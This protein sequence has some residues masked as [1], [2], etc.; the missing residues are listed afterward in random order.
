[1]S[2]DS[3]GPLGHL[4]D[5]A[6]FCTPEEVS[7]FSEPKATEAIE[8][9]IDGIKW[10]PREDLKDL[11]T[12]CDLKT[13]CKLRRV[14]QYWK[15]LVS[16][17]EV[18]E[19]AVIDRTCLN[20]SRGEDHLLSKKEP[21]KPSRLHSH[22]RRHG[23]MGDHVRAIIFVCRGPAEPWDRVRSRETTR[24]TGDLSHLFRLIRLIGLFCS[25][26]RQVVLLRMVQDSW[27]GIG[28]CARTLQERLSHPAHLPSGF[29]HLQV[30]I[31]MDANFCFYVNSPGYRR[32]IW[33]KVPLLQCELTGDPADDVQINLERFIWPYPSAQRDWLARNVPK[34]TAK[35]QAW[36]EENKANAL[37]LWGEVSDG[38]ADW[39][40]FRAGKYE[41]MSAASLRVLAWILQTRPSG[42]VCDS[43]DSDCDGEELIQ[44][45]SEDVDIEAPPFLID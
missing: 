45:V 7:I 13:R 31:L 4:S 20:V 21:R 39:E 6:S 28:K 16:L 8:P 27:G 3:I 32:A 5:Y 25:Q 1:M 44:A 30:L 15:Y 43:D 36:L 12:F 23:L 22:M 37:V 9:I 42:C 18:N 38:Y 11:F 10:V 34:L 29:A 19:V 24:T 2:H 41:K 40:L 33:V 17:L 35:Y 26:V 14:S